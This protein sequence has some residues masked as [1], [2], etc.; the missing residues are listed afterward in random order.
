VHGGVFSRLP[1]DYE[2]PTAGVYDLWIKWNTRDTVRGIPPLNSLHPKEYKFL[3]S[4]PKPDG[5]K[6]RA[7]RQTYSDM[8]FICNCIEKAATECGMDPS[9]GS[10]TNIRLI[11]EQVWPTIYEG[12]KGGRS[13]Q[14]KWPTLVD[15]LRKRK[16]MEKDKAQGG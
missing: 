2:F 14:S 4:K 7:S 8:K 3:D 12:V 10:S 16:N 15:K 5:S 13:T 9:D 6:R 1:A 11:Y